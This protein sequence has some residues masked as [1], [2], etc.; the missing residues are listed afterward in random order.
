MV[1][2]TALKKLTYL[3]GDVIDARGRGVQATRHKA[4]G[5]KECS[6]VALHGFRAHLKRVVSR[7][8]P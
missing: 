1:V 6:R 4:C 5:D 8:R 3:E 7:I 2:E